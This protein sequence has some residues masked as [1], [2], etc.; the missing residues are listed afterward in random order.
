LQA[1]WTI[2]PRLSFTGRYEHFKADTV[3]QRANLK[4]SD[5]WAG[6]LSFRF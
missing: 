4:S 2:T 1:V 5:F 6:W 3:L